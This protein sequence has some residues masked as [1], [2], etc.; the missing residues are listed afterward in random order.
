MLRGYSFRPRWPLALAAAGCAAGIALGNWQTRRGAEKLALAEAQAASLRGP[1]IRIGAAPVR[2][3]DLVQR[4]VEATGSFAA[5][6]TVY[7]DNRNRG[8]RPG[9][10]AVTPLMLSPSAAVLV[11]RG[12]VERGA[13]ASVRTPAVVERIEGIALAR[14]PRAFAFAGD[15][16]GEVRQNLDIEGY[17]KETGLALQPVVIQQRNDDGDGLARDW[18]RPDAGVDMHRAYALQWYA[19]AAL[20]AVLG[21]VF[22]FRRGAQG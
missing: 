8:G 12:W 5:A 16:Q 13:R 22:S 4:H 15:G 11:Q 14:L 2:A 19:L 3:G 1:P 17:A 9:Y 10:E 21:I 20:A 6:R 7:L 18:P